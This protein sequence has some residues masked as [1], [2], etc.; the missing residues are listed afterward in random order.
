MWS[1]RKRIFRHIEFKKEQK[2]D[3][4]LA[5]LWRQ[6]GISHLR[7][8][9]ISYCNMRNTLGRRVGGV[10]SAFPDFYQV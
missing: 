3:W 5:N 2:T 8:K 6:P 9:V 4:A 10:F 1:S 7:L